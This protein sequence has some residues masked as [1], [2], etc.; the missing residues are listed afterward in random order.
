M[1]ESFMGGKMDN[2]PRGL[3]SAE[4]N[5][6][7]WRHQRGGRDMD[8]SACS[9]EMPLDIIIDVDSMSLQGSGERPSKHPIQQ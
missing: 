1:T 7:V 2:F 5:K 8:H 4:N 9:T 3:T 6:V